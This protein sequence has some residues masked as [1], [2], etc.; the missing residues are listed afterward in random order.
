MSELNEEG[1][2]AERN[3]YFS[4]S[5]AESL[6]KEVEAHP[7]EYASYGAELDQAALHLLRASSLVKSLPKKGGL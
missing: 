6:A 2:Y 7:E 1:T 4:L 3:I 5:D